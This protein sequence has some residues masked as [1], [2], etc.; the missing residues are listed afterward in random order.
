MIATGILL[1]LLIG[2]GTLTGLWLIY[3]WKRNPAVVDLG[4]AIGLTIM[5]LTHNLSSFTLSTGN[6]LTSLLVLLWGLRLG[7]YLFWTRLR[8]GKK[9]A[10]YESLHRQSNIPAPLF[11]LIHYLIQA[12]FQAAVGFVFIFTAQ[13]AAFDSIWA[14]AGLMLWCVGYGGSIAAD[15]QL[16]RFRTRS[17][18][19]DK[20]CHVGLWNYSRHPNYFFEILLWSGFALIGLPT[21]LG[22]LGLISP[23]T[24]LLTMKFIT[25]P[26]SERQ[27]LKSKPDAYSQ[28]QKTT[29]MIIPWLKSN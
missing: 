24:L 14:K 6:L 22:W 16:H 28:Y 26:I 10:R 17:D 18:N 13:S 25:G 20:V 2:A 3:L 9:D 5:G 19:R 23:I 21:R 8:L 27:S 1:N 12:C 7:G 4:W 15:A 29:S 11:F